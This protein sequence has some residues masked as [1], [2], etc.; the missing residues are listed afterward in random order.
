MVDAT[1]LNDALAANYMLVDLEIRAW[2]G[3]KTDSAASSEVIANKGAIKGSG[4]FVTALLAGADKELKEVKS[5]GSAIRT[6]VYSH[7]LPWSA[8]T[9]GARR[10]SRLLAAKSSLDFLR[11]LN[12]IKKEYDASV[13]RLI[14]VWPH[15]I[16]EAMSNLGGLGDPD[17][18]PSASELGRL[19]S[20][21][22]DLSPVPAMADF[23]RIGVPSSLAEAL[24]ARHANQAE[25]KLHVALDDLKEQLLKELSRMAVQMG[26]V[27]AGEQ[28]RLYDSLVTN[29]QTLV[30]L[31]RSMNVANNPHL[32]DLADKIEKQLLAQPVSALKNS[33]QK[34]GE[35]ADAAKQL[36]IDAAMENVWQL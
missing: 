13:A 12:A 2:N 7:T 27:V 33:V 16:S 10:G 21:S 8:N 26:K 22:V 20:V 29:L 18:Y 15:R 35:V 6:Y 14:V 4:R 25:Q 23:S 5:M 32:T 30:R 19:F 34:A 17:N 24:G 36:A 11:D 3:N 31:A 1:E 9:D 28:T